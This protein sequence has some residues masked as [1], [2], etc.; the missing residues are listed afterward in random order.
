MLVAGGLAVVL[1]LLGLG[2]FTLERSRL[3]A[4]ERSGGST[5]RGWSTGRR[6][7]PRWPTTR[8]CWIGPPPTPRSRRVSRSPTRRLLAGFASSFTGERNRSVALFDPAGHVTANL[9]PAGAPSVEDLG[10]AW[11]AALAGRPAVSPVFVFDGVP[12]RATVAPVGGT[13]PWAVLVTVNTDQRG[14]ARAM[15]IKAFSGQS[16][17]GVSDVDTA[18]IAIAS[19]DPGLV[20]KRVVDPAELA[21]TDPAAPRTW[22]VGEGDGQVTYVAERQTSTGYTTVF[23][24]RSADLYADL[25]EQ[26]ERRDVTLGA[27]LGACLV[28][29]VGFGLVL[30]RGLVRRRARTDALLAGTGDLVL[31]TAKDEDDRQVA[32]CDQRPPAG[33][34]RLARRGTPTPG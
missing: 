11:Q 25:R 14:Q 27:V 4:E 22:T 23:Q 19:W 1:V 32:R 7:L 28:G 24:Q 3:H 2:V 17:G 16:R 31:V 9:L 8:P 21:G 18:G 13:D 30:Q 20:G 26:Q 29:L 15:G 34:R 33:E 5:W 12:M 10:A 6:V